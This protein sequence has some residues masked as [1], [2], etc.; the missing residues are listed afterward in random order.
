MGNPPAGRDVLP[1]DGRVSAPQA[2]LRSAR[3]VPE[4]LAPALQAD[5]RR[6]AVMARRIRIQPRRGL[7]MRRLVRSFAVLTAVLALG[8]CDALIASFIRPSGGMRPTG[9]AAAIDHDVTPTTSD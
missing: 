1:A 4:R 6:S 2:A 5:V 7:R 9:Y 3:G 8:G